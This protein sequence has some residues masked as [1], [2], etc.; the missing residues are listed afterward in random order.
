MGFS[1]PSNFLNLTL[2]NLSISFNPGDKQIAMKGESA[3]GQLQLLIKRSAQGRWQFATAMSPPDNWRFSA[4][5]S[6]LSSLDGIGFGGT[7]L[8]ASNFEGRTLPTDFFELPD[9]TQISKG[10]NLVANLDTSNLGLDDLMDLD[11]LTVSAAIGPNPAS[12]VPWAIW[13]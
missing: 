13:R 4:L 9:G 11:S 7:Q 5:D 8:L 12:L 3:L 1:A 6:S 2:N 10:L